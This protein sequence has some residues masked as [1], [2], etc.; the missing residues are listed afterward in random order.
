[1]AGVKKLDFDSPDETRTPEKTRAELVRVG[2]TTVGRLTLQ[3]GWQWSDCIKP[4]V[5]TDSA[6]SGM[7]ELFNRARCMLSTTM[8]QK[9]I[10]DPAMLMSSSQVTTHG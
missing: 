6:R 3:P 10:S 9:R 1:M 7:W 5:G 4:V 2:S 8:G